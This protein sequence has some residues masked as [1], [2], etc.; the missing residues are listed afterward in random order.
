M[1][2]PD[3]K[4]RRVRSLLSSY[5]GSSGSDAPPGSASAPPAEPID[6]ESFDAES[7]VA[8]VVKS[9]PLPELHARCASM[10]SEIASLDGDMQMLVYENYS[11]FITATDT[12]RRMRGNVDGMDEKMEELRATV[13]ATAAASDA[14]NLKLGAHREQI[15]NLNGVRSL[16]KKLQAAFDLP[17]RLRACVETNALASGVEYYV[18]ARPL[19]VKYGDEGAFVGIKR[20][21]DAVAAVVKEKL[22]RGMATAAERAKK[23]AERKRLLAAKAIAEEDGGDEGA[24]EEKTTPAAGG[25]GADADADDDDF[26][27]DVGE[28]VDLL[29]KLGEPRDE[30]QGEYLSARRA[31]LDDALSA[32]EARATEGE[33][34]GETSGENPTYFVATLDRAFLTEFHAAAS[35]FAELFPRDRAPLVTFSRAIFAR[36]FALLT[37]ALGSGD[38]AAGRA[39][40]PNAKGLMRALAAVAG[41]VR[42]SHRLVPEIN[43]LDRASETTE[44]TVRGRVEASFRVLE[45][46]LAT[47]LD[48]AE[49]IVANAADASSRVDATPPTTPTTAATAT[50][51][52]A[53]LSSASASGGEQTPT[54]KTTDASG[55]PLLLRQFVTLSETLLSGVG[56]ALE[57]VRSLIEERPAL[58]SGWR[59]EYER[60]VKAH[61]SSLLRS[62][63][64]RLR[65]AS[66]AR[67][68]AETLS[69]LATDSPLAPGASRRRPAPAP[70]LLTLARLAT[71][72]RTDGIPHLERELR[73]F[74]P[75]TS[76][77]V[78]DAAFDGDE[79]ATAAEDAATALVE[80]YV[81]ASGRRLAVMIRRSVDAANWLETREP[82]DVRPLC[83]F[84]LEDLAGIEAETGQ[85]LDDG[86][87]G[88]SD[89]GMGAGASSLLS[90]AQQTPIGRRKIEA[91]V[92]R[93]L[94][95]EEEDDGAGRTFDAPIEATQ[96]SVLAAVTRHA[97]KSLVECVRLQTF[98]RAGYQ[99]MT[100]DVAF[101][102]PR[103]RRFVSGDVNGRATAALVEEVRNAAAERSVDPTPLDPVVLARILEFRFK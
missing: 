90:P 36:Y 30:L 40:L 70:L 55:A 12:I 2:D 45:R 98:G 88:A 1:A 25:G 24:E 32:A 65:A 79:W 74:F 103:V 56:D 66:G 73:A 6:T 62:L 82:R 99:Q 44:R 35:E 63:L 51:A 38:G 102:G 92:A 8:S 14:V 3:E 41:D 50:A 94:G 21:S 68:A 97:L 75:T 64:A 57:D 11:K 87:H 10:A 53:T 31:A 91:G 96:A 80:A 29:E 39:R 95:E 7:Y 93:A 34:S 52:F 85:I 33:T 5:Y 72:L 59:E 37:R 20:E 69:R 19:L 9:T 101:L 84:L 77:D 47:A 71:F 78:D 48:D 81:D 83:D 61:V 89:G 16:I 43:V 26:G 42:E 27:L 13:S 54:K 100:V 49:E 60:A 15:E 22:K 58:V 67:L 4:A 23:R 18:A 86:G 28:C 46:K 17:G 76:R